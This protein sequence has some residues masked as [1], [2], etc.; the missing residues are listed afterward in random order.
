MWKL[1]QQWMGV[2]SRPGLNIFLIFIPILFPWTLLLTCTHQPV[3][4]PGHWD[5]LVIKAVI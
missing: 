3:P 5:S 2:R 4:T 1:S